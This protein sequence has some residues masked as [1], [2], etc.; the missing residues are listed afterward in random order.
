MRALDPLVV[1]SRE[2]GER[3]GEG[4]PTFVWSCWKWV[5]CFTNVEPCPALRLRVL[6]WQATRHAP[7][8]KKTCYQLGVRLVKSRVFS[9]GT[10]SEI[11]LKEATGKSFR[12]GACLV[13]QV[14]LPSE[15]PPQM[16]PGKSSIPSCSQLAKANL[17]VSQV[18]W[19]RGGRAGGREELQF[20]SS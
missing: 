3:I 17:K 15:K 13:K 6:R 12:D 16:W 19:M 8:S 18:H 9:L 20:V 7:G 4:T 10:P 5:G 11:V 1:C 14:A 2:L